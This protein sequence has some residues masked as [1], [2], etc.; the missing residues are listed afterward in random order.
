MR[1]SH[2]TV[3]SARLLWPQMDRGFDRDAGERLVGRFGATVCERTFEPVFRAA[4]EPWTIRSP[5]ARFASTAADEAAS[6]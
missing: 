1:T 5:V 4:Q 2:P 6:V 3:D